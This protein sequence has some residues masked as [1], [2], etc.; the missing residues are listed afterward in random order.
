MVTNNNIKISG[1]GGPK[2]FDH[3]VQSAKELG[4]KIVVDCTTR[5]S[6]R[7]AHRK[8]KDLVCYMVDD[9]EALNPHPGT[10]GRDFVWYVLNPFC[11]EHFYKR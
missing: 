8:Y 10:D 4:I 5:L 7:L 11:T 9:Q 1:L 2:E 6:A 3:L